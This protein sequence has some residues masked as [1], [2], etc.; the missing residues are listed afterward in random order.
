MW[1]VSFEDPLK[2][3]YG[4]TRIKQDLAEMGNRNIYRT[5]SSERTPTKTENK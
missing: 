3:G 5:S 2:M 4:T 1:R